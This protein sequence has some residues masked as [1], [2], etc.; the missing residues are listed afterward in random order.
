[1]DQLNMSCRVAAANARL[2]VLR[3]PDWVI[4]TIIPVTDVP[5]FDPM[6]TGTAVLTVITK[7]I[8]LF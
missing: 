4:E 7:N 5:M 6:T 3:S 8:Q 2:K 1:M